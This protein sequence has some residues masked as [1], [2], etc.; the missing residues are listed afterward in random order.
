MVTGG[1]GSSSPCTQ[2]ARLD[3]PIFVSP[4]Q[5]ERRLDAVLAIQDCMA[6]QRLPNV[7]PC[8]RRTVSLADLWD[9]FSVRWTVRCCNVFHA[10][11]NRVA[12]ASKNLAVRISS[13]A[14]RMNCSSQAMPRE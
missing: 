11:L 5:F 10:R 4:L 3:A 12:D 8:E 6:R 13:K 9:C 7:S 14:A 1:C 2:H